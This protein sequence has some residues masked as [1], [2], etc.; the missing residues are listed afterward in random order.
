MIHV[1]LVVEPEHRGETIPDGPDNSRG[2]L[3]RDKDAR[4][5]ESHV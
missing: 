5:A 3:I 4:N 1:V 2:F